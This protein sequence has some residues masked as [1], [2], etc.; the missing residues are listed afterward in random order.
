ML[1]I[2]LGLDN[3]A[4]TGSID[5]M[6]NTSNTAENKIKI[7]KSNALFFSL[8]E[9]IANIFFKLFIKNK[10]LITIVWF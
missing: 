1:S 5:A 3:N 7:N 4:I 2:K 8:F 9:R 6:P 10:K